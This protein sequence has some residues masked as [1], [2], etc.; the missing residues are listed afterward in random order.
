M[1]KKIRLTLACLLAP[2]EFKQMSDAILLA[3]DTIKEQDKLI[4]EQNK[5]LHHPVR[6]NFELGGHKY[7]TYIDNVMSANGKAFNAKVED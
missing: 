3:N 6:I 1:F 7:S 5:L 2:K 4:G